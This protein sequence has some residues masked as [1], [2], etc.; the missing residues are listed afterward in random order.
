MTEPIM[1]PVELAVHLAFAKVELLEW[2]AGKRSPQD[3]PGLEMIGR[4]VIKARGPEE[5]IFERPPI[6]EA[7]WWVVFDPAGRVVDQGPGEASESG[8]RPKLRMVVNNDPPE[9]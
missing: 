2:Q 5:V 4:V 1:D 6:D 8:Y 3:C 9:R 7:L